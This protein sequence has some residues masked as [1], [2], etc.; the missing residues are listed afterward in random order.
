MGHQTDYRSPM[1][2]DPM[3]MRKDTTYNK[4]RHRERLLHIYIEDE[5]GI[6]LETIDERG[7]PMLVLDTKTDR[8]LP[9][10]H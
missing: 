5:G 1:T 10:R 9:Q 2:G 4:A 7:V 3:E 6:Y 8:Q